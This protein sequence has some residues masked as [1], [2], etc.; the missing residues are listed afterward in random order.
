MADNKT[1]ARRLKNM[2][3]TIETPRTDELF[4]KLA[5]KKRGHGFAEM[6]SLA[7]EL[8]RELAECRNEFATLSKACGNWR[9]FNAPAEP[10]NI[11][12]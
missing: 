11:P 10:S 9:E 4:D 6:F 7:R 8:E 2:K 3:T 1:P 5:H 12:S